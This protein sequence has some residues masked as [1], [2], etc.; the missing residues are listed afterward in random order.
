MTVANVTRDDI[1]FALEIAGAAVATAVLTGS[2][3]VGDSI[4]ASLRDLTLERLGRVEQAVTGERLFAAALADRLDESTDSTAIPILALRGA[5]LH[6]ASG[7]RAARVGIWGVDERFADL[8]PGDAA[9]ARLDLTRRQGQLFPS[10]V[11][12]AALAR[13]LAA[14][15]GDEVLLQFARQGEVPRATLLGE[16]EATAALRSLRLTVTAVLPNRGAGRFS[17]A[18]NQ[19]LPLNAFVERDTTP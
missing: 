5:A 10:L 12:N 11:I 4:Q 13:E 2:L 6:A 9:A 19:T 1:R 8:F 17:L 3:V 16:S 15:P 18:A 7:A 14:E